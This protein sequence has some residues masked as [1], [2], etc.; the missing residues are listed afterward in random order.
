[1]TD[2]HAI[3]TV[4]ITGRVQGVGYREWTRR[5]AIALGLT[6]WVRNE[7]DGSVVALIAGSGQAVATLVDRLWKGP[8]LASVTGATTGIAETTEIPKDF[9]IAR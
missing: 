7:A 5:Q 2:E 3:L 6:G 9:R 1:M 8:Q 4:R